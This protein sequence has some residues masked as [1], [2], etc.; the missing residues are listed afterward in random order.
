MKLISFGLEG[1]EET[2]L[3]LAQG[4]T[5]KIRGKNSFEKTK[6]E[7]PLELQKEGRGNR[8]HKTI[9]GEKIEGVDLILVNKSTQDLQ[10]PL[11]GNSLKV[12]Y[13]KEGTKKVLTFTDGSN[14]E[15]EAVLGL[16]I[17]DGNKL[18][19]D[20]EDKANFKHSFDA[21]GKYSMLS[22][23]FLIEANKKF[24]FAFWSEGRSGRQDLLAEFTGEEFLVSEVP[25]TREDKE[26]LILNPEETLELE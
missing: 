14:T 7:I 20:P 10:F 25:K 6:E 11:T 26:A 21:L 12:S 19:I 4:K 3:V 22:G 9:K 1:T 24:N 23:A 13:A 16:V 8:T 15:E 2:P 18:A 17:V 5:L